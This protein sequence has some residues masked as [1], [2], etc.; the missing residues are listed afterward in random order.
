MWVS[1]LCFLYSV[2]FRLKIFYKLHKK[3][4]EIQK[5]K[6]II[7]KRIIMISM[8]EKGFDFF[9]VKDKSDNIH[10]Y[11]HTYNTY[12]VRNSTNVHVQNM[13][14]SDQLPRHKRYIH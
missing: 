11:S 10:I 13:L 3:E 9:S 4:I 5:S 7:P 2:A 14:N 12:Q 1:V 8:E 6:M